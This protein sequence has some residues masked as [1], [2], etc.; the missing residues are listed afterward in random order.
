MVHLVWGRK[1]WTIFCRVFSGAGFCTS[2]SPNSCNRIKFL[3]LFGAGPTQANY[4]P[5]SFYMNLCH[6]RTSLSPISL[7]ESS[8]FSWNR[9]CFILFL[10]AKPL[11]W[12][13][14]ASI[15]E[16]ENKQKS[17]SP[18]S[19][20]TTSESLMQNKKLANHID[21]PGQCSP[22]IDQYF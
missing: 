11:C 17:K 1:M 5:K 20:E 18:S 6:A 16:R 13:L 7:L 12:I 2:P 14:K 10:Q 22:M 3:S 8:L 15:I 9:P 19:A 21:R 4:G